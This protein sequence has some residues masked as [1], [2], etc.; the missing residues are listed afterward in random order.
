MEQAKC[1]EV[2]R[3][4]ICDLLTSFAKIDKKVQKLLTST[5]FKTRDPEFQTEMI[6]W[7]DIAHQLVDFSSDKFVKIPEMRNAIN[8]MEQLYAVATGDIP[9][10]LYNIVHEYWCGYGNF[11]QDCRKKLHAS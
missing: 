2:E 3:K 5:Q 8:Q 11:T 10:F 4:S 9:T 7:R 1:N 6:Y